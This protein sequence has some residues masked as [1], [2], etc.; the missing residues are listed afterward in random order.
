MTHERGGCPEIGG[1]GTL[2]SGPDE[3]PGNGGP[4]T[5]PGRGQTVA[6]G[7]SHLPGGGRTRDG[8]GKGQGRG[9]EGLSHQGGVVREGGRREDEEGTAQNLHLPRADLENTPANLRRGG[10]G[11]RGTVCVFISYLFNVQVLIINLFRSVSA[12]PSPEK[13]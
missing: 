10:E 8:R 4:G 5:P 7:G 1:D 11:K 9:G 2:L 12:S 6:L 13:M 3:T